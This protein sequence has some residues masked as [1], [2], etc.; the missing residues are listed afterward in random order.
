MKLLFVIIQKEDTKTLTDALIDNDFSI[1]RISSTGG[2]LSGGNTTLM[3]GMEPERVERCLEL[4]KE[5]S[6]RRRTVTA[7]VNLQ[8][9]SM[10]ATAAPFTVTVGGAT[11]FVVDAEAFYKF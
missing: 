2:F 11:V 5:K 9:R 6:S 8:P 3:L 1:T 4:I 10:D 7:P